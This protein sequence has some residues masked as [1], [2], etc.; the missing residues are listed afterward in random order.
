MRA[1]DISNLKIRDVDWKNEF[2]HLIQEKTGHTLDIPLRAS[3]GNAMMDYLLE[4]RQESNQP[5]FFSSAKH[6][7]VKSCLIAAYSRSCR[8]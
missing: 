5:S 2:I 3:Y 7:T 6:H 1:I 8:Q 4:E